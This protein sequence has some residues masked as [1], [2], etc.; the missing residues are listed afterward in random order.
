MMDPMEPAPIFILGLQRSGTNMMLGLLGH[1][2]G[3]A[4]FERMVEM[5][6]LEIVYEAPRCIDYATAPGE[7]CPPESVYFDRIYRVVP[8]ATLPDTLAAR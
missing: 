3:L 5:G 8:G 4:K 2:P 7:N 1:A 6:L